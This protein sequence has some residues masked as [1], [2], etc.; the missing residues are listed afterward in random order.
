MSLFLLTSLADL[1]G[2]KSQD[3]LL[4]REE[5][6]HLNERLFAF[7][8]QLPPGFGPCQNFTNRALREPQHIMA[9]HTLADVMLQQLLLHLEGYLCRVHLVLVPRSGAAAFRLVAGQASVNAAHPCRHV[10]ARH[11]GD[12]GC[13]EGGGKGH[14]ALL[15]KVS[16]EEMLV[17]NVVSRQSVHRARGHREGT[18]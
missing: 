1:D 13:V 14:E 4:I 18:W 5:L 12:F 8:S 2:S 3:V 16:R 10:C 7:H 11:Q 6:L 9:K 15:F 17:K